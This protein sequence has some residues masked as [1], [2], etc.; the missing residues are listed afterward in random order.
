[1]PI[2]FHC[3]IVAPA[4]A[5]TP[6]ISSDWTRP[7]LLERIARTFSGLR[8]VCAHLGVPWFEEAATLSRLVPNIH[9][10]ITGAYDGWRA[11][12]T[13]AFFKEM[14]WDEGAWQRVVFGS[15]E[16]YDKLALILKRDRKLLEELR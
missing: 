14:L 6:N 3:G 10:D 9:L 11:G 4:V 8:L 7:I 2:L 13:T 5:Y 15:D 16:H 1:M 12:K